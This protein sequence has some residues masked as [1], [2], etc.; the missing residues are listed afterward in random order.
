MTILGDHIVE[1]EVQ[2]LEN[3]M[4]CMLQSFLCPILPFYHVS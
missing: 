3:G 4:G 1:N 2:N